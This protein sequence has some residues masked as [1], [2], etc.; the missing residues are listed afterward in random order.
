MRNEHPTQYGI[1]DHS[2]DVYWF[3]YGYPKPAMTYYFNDQIIE[4]GGRF[5]WSLTRNGQATLFVNRMMERDAGVY[6]AVATNEYGCARQKIKV[7]LAEYPRFIQRP[8]EVFI[9]SRRSGRLEAKLVGVPLPE[10]KWFKDWQPLAESTRLKI[11]FY[12]PDTYVL[13][14]TD[15]LKKDEGLYSLT[16]RNHAGTISASAMV[17]IEENEED[18]IFNA[19][20]RTPYVR[21]RQKP[22]YNDIYDI[23][24]ELGRGTQGVTYHAVERATGRNFAAKIMHGR[25]ELRPVMF[26]ELDI[27][28]SLNHRKLIRLHDAYDTKNTLVMIEELA[29][30]G[31]LVRDNLLRR[32]FYTERQISIF[33]YQVLQGL[34][35]MHTRTIGHMGLNVR[36][37]IQVF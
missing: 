12:E 36:I 21:S 5:N 8:E 35:H 13:L 16:A 1:K 19:H 37:K 27:M 2:V 17:H 24:D 9:M 28:N 23:G 29:A 32:D 4:S 25:P 3:V 6:E 10:I 15:A 14:I 11:I 18:Y 20:H 7:E 33:M 30:G 22:Y 34:E 31:E 26:N